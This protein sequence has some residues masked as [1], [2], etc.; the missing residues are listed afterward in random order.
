MIAILSTFLLITFVPVDPGLPD[1]THGS[2]VRACPAE[3]CPDIERS[4]VELYTEGVL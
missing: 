2:G 4:I 1:N 3:V